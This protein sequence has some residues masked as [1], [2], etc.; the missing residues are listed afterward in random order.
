M[1]SQKLTKTNNNQKERKKERKKENKITYCLATA[2][3]KKG[4]LA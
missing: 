1:V 4:G 2:E 3:W